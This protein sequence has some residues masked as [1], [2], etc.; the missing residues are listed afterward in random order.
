MERLLRIL[1]SSRSRRSTASSLRISQ[2]I[3]LDRCIPPLV[4]ARTTSWLQRAS[5]DENG[6]KEDK[7]YTVKTECIQQEYQAA[8]SKAEADRQAA[9]ARVEV[10]RRATEAAQKKAEN[11]CKNTIAKANEQLQATTKERAEV[12]AQLQEAKKT[13]TAAEENVTETRKKVSGE[14]TRGSTDALAG[15]FLKAYGFY[16]RCKIILHTTLPQHGQGH[17]VVARTIFS[18]ANNRKR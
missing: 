18:R 5:N 12:T 7:H 16:F 9:L 1:T 15:T 3:D 6:K 11:V 10:E 17:Y 8:L 4:D 14:E 13:S 2:Q